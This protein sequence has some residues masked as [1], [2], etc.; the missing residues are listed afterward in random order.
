MFRIRKR[1]KYMPLKLVEVFIILRK[2]ILVIYIYIQICAC[3]SWDIA[4][5]VGLD[6]SFDNRNRKGIW[7]KWEV[8]KYESLYTIDETSRWVL[9]GFYIN[10][11]ENVF[12]YRKY[13]RAIS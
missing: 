2:L 3:Y 13:Y 5:D 4:S 7:E 6:V 8:N 9:N 11:S 10:Y 1:L 12:Y